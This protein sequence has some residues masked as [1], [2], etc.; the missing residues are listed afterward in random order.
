MKS[1]QNR[2]NRELEP[3]AAPGRTWG[4]K[5]ALVEEKQL[6]TEG[7]FSVNYKYEKSSYFFLIL[8]F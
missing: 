8:L 4:G 1:I 5:E 3:A 2:G 7:D 6:L